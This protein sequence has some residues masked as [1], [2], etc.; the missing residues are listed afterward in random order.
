MAHAPAI[1]CDQIT[2]L[3]ALAI[4]EDLGSG[5]VTSEAVVDDS[6]RTCACFVIR[7]DGVAAG[8]PVVEYVFGKFADRL[9]DK[10]RK[11]RSDEIE[12]ATKVREGQEVH[13]GDVLATVDGPA[14]VLLSGERLSLN[15]MQ[16]MSGIATLTRQYV[17]A[18]KDYPAEILDTRKT[19]PGWR[20]LA[21]YAV[22]A[23][24]GANHRTGL[25]DMVLLK[26]NH[27]QMAAKRWPDGDPIKRAIAAA[28]EHAAKGMLIEVETENIEQVRAAIEA[29]AD[30]IM[31]DNMSL[32]EMTEADN[33]VKADSRDI[34][35]EASGGV[36]L[37]RV[38]EIAQTGVDRIS[39]GALTHSARALDIAMEM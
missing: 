33:L 11:V 4:D 7:E 9:E 6:A 15:F 3:V 32:D 16:R 31:F 34:L 29:G 26:D 10:G 1:D 20:Y 23:G 13:A 21:K 2:D 12:F 22:R 14:L 24:G 18:V 5:D 38:V 25:Y 8:L 36:T 28:R 37:E 39:I 35:T 19:T 17:E 27:L 30:I